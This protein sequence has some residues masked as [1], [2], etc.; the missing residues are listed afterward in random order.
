MKKMALVPHSMVEKLMNAQR[1]QQQLVSDT[2]MTQLSLLD[3]ELKQ[4]LDN[5][6]PADV[7][8]KK[9][10]QVLQTY[11]T[12][13]DKEVRQ[14]ASVVN[15]EKRE[16]WLTGMANTYV[17][18]GRLLIDHVQKNPDLQ[19]NEKNEIFYKGNR[20]PGSNVIDL[21][22]TYVKRNN[23]QPIG[24]REFGQALIEQNAP[25]TAINNEKLINLARVPSESELKDQ[26]NAIKAE[27]PHDVEGP[28][29]L[30]PTMTQRRMARRRTPIYSSKK[31]DKTKWQNL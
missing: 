11:S 15:T 18:K 31:L 30:T 2:P 12:I 25:L 14:P 3:Q 7:K 26:I 28:T 4:L 9:Y 27:P 1:E 17:N 24:W 5:Q 21:I 8:A 16:N 20:I 23:K 6:D 19:W 22:H 29:K 10:A 13:R